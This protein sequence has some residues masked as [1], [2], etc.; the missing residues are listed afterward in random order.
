MGTNDDAFLLD[1]SRQH[2]VERLTNLVTDG[3]IALAVNFSMRAEMPSGPF[4][5]VSMA[6][7]DEIRDF[8]WVKL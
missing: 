4:A 1:G 2:M 8:G 6:C 7:L 5:F 3:I